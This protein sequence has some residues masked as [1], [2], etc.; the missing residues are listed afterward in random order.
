MSIPNIPVPTVARVEA[1]HK[2]IWDYL[3]TGL[4][5]DEANTVKH[6]AEANTKALL[7]G[8]IARKKQEAP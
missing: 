5:F 1:L 3:R 6:E 2:A 7:D 8:M 4:S